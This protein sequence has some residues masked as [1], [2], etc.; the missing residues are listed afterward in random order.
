MITE[1][2]LYLETFTATWAHVI[3]MGA[4]VLFVIWYGYYYTENP[5]RH[6]YARIFWT[7]EGWWALR[8]GGLFDST[9]GPYLT[10]ELAIAAMEKEDDDAKV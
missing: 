10:K 2:C 6:P 9:R 1:L 7:H 3:A 8:P 5:R 4:V